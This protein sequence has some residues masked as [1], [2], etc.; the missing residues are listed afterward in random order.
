MSLSSSSESTSV[1]VC[2]VFSVTSLLGIVRLS[3]TSFIDDNLRFLFVAYCLS[4]SD[5]V[6]FVIIVSVSSLAL[7]CLNV[8]KPILQDVIF[9]FYVYSSA[10]SESSLFFNAIPISLDSLMIYLYCYNSS[11]SE[12]FFNEL[13]LFLPFLLDASDSFD[14]SIIVLTSCSDFK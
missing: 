3:F 9:E 5:F 10:I 4:N 13:P 1:S 6:V 2:L 11:L 12:L 7:P 14:S 8:S